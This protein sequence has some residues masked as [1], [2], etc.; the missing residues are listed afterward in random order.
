MCSWHTI[1]QKELRN[2][3]SE[4]LRRVE[5]GETLIV[6]VAGRE[7]AELRPLHRRRWVSGQSLNRVWDG[8]TP[9]GMDADLGKLDAGLNDPYRR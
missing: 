9:R 3:V 5:A 6:T 2:Q 1:P 8:P 7:V 4:V